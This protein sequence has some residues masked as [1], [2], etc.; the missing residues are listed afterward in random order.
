M[1]WKTMLRQFSKMELI[2][3]KDLLENKLLTSIPLG[4]VKEEIDKRYQPDDDEDKFV[5]VNKEIDINEGVDLSSLSKV[6]KSKSWVSIKLIEAKAQQKAIY[7]ALGRLHREHDETGRAI[8]SIH[9]LLENLEKSF[10]LEPLGINTFGQK[11]D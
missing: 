1:N 10:G 8:D 4:L 5:V 6:H 2:R 9:G 3:I 7:E 11:N